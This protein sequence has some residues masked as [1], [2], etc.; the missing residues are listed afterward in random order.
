M[1][2]TLQHFA[3][4]LQVFLGQL[5]AVGSELIQQGFH[6]MGDGLYFCDIKKAGGPFDT[7]QTGMSSV[8]IIRTASGIYR[9]YPAR[10][11]GSIS[12]CRHYICA[13]YNVGGK[14]PD[15]KTACDSDNICSVGVDIECLSRALSPGFARR[16]LNAEEQRTL[17]NE[18]GSGT[19]TRTEN[20]ASHCSTE[21]IRIFSAKEAVYKACRQHIPNLKMLAGITLTPA[22]VSEAAFHFRA[23]F[24]DAKDNTYNNICGRPFKLH[25]RRSQTD[26]F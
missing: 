1:M 18:Y 10:I 6:L 15:N 26:C 16:L 3:D 5:F 9:W 7:G 2:E 25:F 17:K 12:H 23:E 19:V 4:I 24:P 20:S 11:T 22:A 13:F 21:L 8:S 14:Q